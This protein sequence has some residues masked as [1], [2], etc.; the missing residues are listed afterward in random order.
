M[1]CLFCEHVTHGSRNL[2]DNL[3]DLKA[4]VAANQ[5][6]ILLVAD[7]IREYTLPTVHAYMT[8][9]RDN[10]EMAVRTVL[11][12]LA[13]KHTRNVFHAHGD[14]PFDICLFAFVDSF[15]Y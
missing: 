11:R 8:H 7:L 2:A 3:E 14:F 6:G 4:Q 15:F 10:A 5:R 1:N 12:D 9:I 13:S